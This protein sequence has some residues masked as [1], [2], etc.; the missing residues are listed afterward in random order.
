MTLPTPTRPTP[1]RPTSTRDKSSQD[2]AA[3]AP[4]WRH[5]TALVLGN[6]ALALGPWWVRLADCGPV[7]TGFWRLALALP[8]LALL[9]WRDRAP[10]AGLTSRQGAAMA[11]AGAF[12]ALDLA[13]W[14]LGIVQ[15]RLGNATLFGNS[16]SLIIM[17]WGLMAAR[18]WPRLIECAALV[19]ALTGAA[20]L[21]GRSLQISPAS[22]A[23]DLLCLLA[24]FFY[25]FYILLLRHAR[26]ALGN[27][28]LLVGASL[29]GAPV[30]LAV[31][32]LLGEPLWPHHWTPLVVLALS[33]QVLGQGLVVYALRHFSALVIGLA[34]LCQPVIGVT[35]GA[36]AFGEGLGPWDLL[37]M[38]LVAGALVMVRAGET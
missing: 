27:W 35:V 34:L 12:F 6:V 15:T 11:A 4:R 7:A 26:A 32:L 38:A 21:F 18:R 5:F 10:A 14:H 36:L 2:I 28:A 9:A 8:V 23:G 31:T 17:A 19:A 16:G 22:L 3:G 37:G 1:T 33:S 25:A 13:S 30:L 24:G 20:I 29:A